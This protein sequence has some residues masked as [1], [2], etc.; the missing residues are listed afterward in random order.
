MYQGK[1]CIV[2]E[3]VEPLS[4]HINN[5]M[6]D[7]IIT[8]L[9]NICSALKFLHETCMLSHNY[10]TID[11]I[12]VSLANYSWKLGCLQ[13]STFFGDES[14]DKLIKLYNCYKLLSNDYIPSED[15]ETDSIKPITKTIEIHRRDSYAL[16]LL[17][18][19]LLENSSA[20]LST[21]I[22]NLTNKSIHMR[23]R[24]AEIL[25]DEL[26]TTCDY[27]KVVNGLADF[28][29]L[30][31]SEKETFLRLLI[32]CLKR[33][34][35]QLIA[36]KLIPLILTNR[37][38]IFHPLAHECILPYLFIS[39][40]NQT[41]P[42]PLINPELFESYVLPVIYK[43]FCVRNIQ[44]RLILLDYLHHYIDYIPLES[45]QT[46]LLPQILLG[47]KDE[48]DSLVSATFQALSL[49][50]SKFGAQTILGPRKKIFQNITPKHVNLISYETN[51]KISEISSNFDSR[52]EP[53]GEEFIETHLTK[54]DSN[55][56]SE[57]ESKNNNHVQNDNKKLDFVDI[58][59]IDII[60]REG[61]E[62]D[63]LFSA[64][65]P[66]FKFNQDHL[67][68]INKVTKASKFDIQAMDETENGWNE[69]SWAT[70]EL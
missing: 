44:M 8:G 36:S 25:E 45:L 51:T 27:L 65:E 70:D 58:K 33:V 63:L 46:L 64:M 54:S 69:E 23:P 59:S 1:K 22:Q 61:Q 60:T 49:L 13:L 6:K 20:V 66:K 57:S 14:S 24:V 40:P 5:L 48:N 3:P 38:V 11:S 16:G 50:V 56:V 68:V 39:S 28:A 9:H 37:F 21:K 35:S 67:V 53:D 32:D 43:L 62:V 41:V 19:Q 2:I 29:S 10:L 15:A 26:F 47:K 42:E 34:P 31:E 12:F 55:S 4:K 17:F 30:K 7:E 52:S 18:S